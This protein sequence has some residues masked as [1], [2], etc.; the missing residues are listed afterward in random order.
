MPILVVGHV[1]NIIGED[2]DGVL[3]ISCELARH[4]KKTYIE[5]RLFRPLG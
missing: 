4:T 3:A 1:K 2:K 5:N